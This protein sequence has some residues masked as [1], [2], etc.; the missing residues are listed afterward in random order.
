MTEIKWIWPR[1]VKVMVTGVNTDPA[2][3]GTL[4]PLAHEDDECAWRM[5]AIVS[6]YE[7]LVWMPDERVNEASAKKWTAE[8]AASAKKECDE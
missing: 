7:A 3:Q 4:T 5:L 2:L 8:L 6:G 1:E